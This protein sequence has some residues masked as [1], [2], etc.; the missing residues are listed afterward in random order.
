MA[1]FYLIN[2]ISLGSFTRYPGELVDDTKEDVAKLVANGAVLWSSSDTAV[3]AA[4]VAAGVAKS[5][6]AGA[7]DLAAIMMAS[8]VSSLRA[9]TN[10]RAEPA[11]FI[12]WLTGSDSNPGTTQATPLKTYAELVRRWGTPYPALTAATVTITIIDH[13]TADN[14]DFALSAVSNAVVTFK[15]LTTTVLQSGTFTATRPKVPATNMPPGLT[16]SAIVGG[17]WP[18]GARVKVTSGVANGAYFWTLKDEGSQLVRCTNASVAGAPVVQPGVGDSYQVE[19]LTD[20]WI[21]GMACNGPKIT[22]ATVNVLDFNVKSST[23]ASIVGVQN[24]TR[25]LNFNR[26]SFANGLNLQKK[27]QRQPAELLRGVV[28]WELLNQLVFPA[29]LLQRRGHWERVEH[30]LRKH[31]FRHYDRWVY[32]TEQATGALCNRSGEW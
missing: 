18:V 21:S 29:Q 9:S 11:W 22:G 31:R 4:A 25:I 20:V 23:G 32:R 27:H 8:T 2:S 30:H 10:Y 12:S 7:V 24:S 5:R 19:T 26:C 6:G 3:A 28:R 1:T 13:N 17:V 16:D 14:I 15:P